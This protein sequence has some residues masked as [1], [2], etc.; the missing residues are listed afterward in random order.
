MAK[1]QHEDIQDPNI[2]EPKN[3]GGANAGDVYEADGAGSG[4]WV[5][6]PHNSISYG[7]LALVSSDPVEVVAVIDAVDDTLRTLDDSLLSQIE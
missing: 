7:D 6:S 2:H 3:I 1:I 5:K 4:V